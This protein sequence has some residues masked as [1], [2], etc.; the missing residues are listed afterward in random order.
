MLKRLLNKHPFLP[1]FLE[2]CLFI[3]ITIFSKV[4]IEIV[5]FLTVDI[6]PTSVSHY[7]ADNA[8]SFKS[9]VTF[10]C[11]GVEPTDFSPRVFT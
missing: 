9:V 2:L 11:R 6:I 8:G 7:D 5:L 4:V 10:D 3:V 1:V